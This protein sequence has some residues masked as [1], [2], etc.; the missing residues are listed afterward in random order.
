MI[1]KIRGL[2]TRVDSPQN[3]KNGQGQYQNIQVTKPPYRDEYGEVKGKEKVYP[4]VLFNKQI[5][6]LKL[7]DKV[8]RKVDVDAYLNSN[9]YQTENGVEYSLNLKLKDIVVLAEG[10]QRNG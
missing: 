7:T 10:G 5:T 6:N 9:E 1:V 3:F 4:I 2:L 8:G